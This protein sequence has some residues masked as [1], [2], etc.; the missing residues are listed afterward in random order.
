MLFTDVVPALEV[1]N[2]HYKSKSA[3][4]LSASEAARR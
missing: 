3:K 1:F 4:A 2:S